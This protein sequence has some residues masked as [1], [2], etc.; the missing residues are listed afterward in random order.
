MS[1]SLHSRPRIRDRG[2]EKV[3]G[4]MGEMEDLGRR[5]GIS[6]PP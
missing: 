1:N 3:V 6:P 4:K 5:K 2:S